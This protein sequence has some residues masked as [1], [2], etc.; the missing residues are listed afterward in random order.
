GER[1]M[2]TIFSIFASLAY[3][4]PIIIVVTWM[5]ITLTFHRKQIEQNNRIIELLENSNEKKVFD[6]SNR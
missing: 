3:L 2:Y 5:I 6:K 4:V 1:Q